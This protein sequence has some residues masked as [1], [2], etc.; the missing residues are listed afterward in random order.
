MGFKIHQNTGFSGMLVKKR[1]A[2]LNASYL[3]SVEHAVFL[4]ILLA[5]LA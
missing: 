4:R 3:E 1:E 2:I 5:G